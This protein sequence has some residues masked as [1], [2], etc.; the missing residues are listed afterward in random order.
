LFNV[1]SSSYYEWLWCRGRDLNPG[2]GLERPAYWA[3]L[4]YRG[5]FVTNSVDSIVSALGVNVG[6]YTPGID[7]KVMIL[8]VLGGSISLSIISGFMGVLLSERAERIRELKEL[9]RKLGASLRGSIYARATTIIPLYVAL[10]S[11]T[12]MLLFPLVMVVPYLA[13]LAGLIGVWEAFLA[14]IAISLVS[15]MA[16]GGYLGV[17]TGEGI[18]ISALRTLGLGL[19]VLIIVLVFKQTFTTLVG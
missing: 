19:L 1:R 5:L 14:S 6:A 3:W 17:I 4:Y 15:L 9:E 2:H 10:W 7:V 11:S 8:A 12:G 18:L 16:I 13:S